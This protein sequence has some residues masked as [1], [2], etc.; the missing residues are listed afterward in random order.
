MSQVQLSLGYDHERPYG[1]LANTAEG[2][3][4]RLRQHDFIVRLCDL[5][6]KEQVSRT[7]FILGDFLERC[8]DSFSVETLRAVYPNT[9]L[10]E[11]QQHS[12]SHKVFRQVPK[13]I[14]P[15]ILSVADFANDVL[16]AGRTIERI[17][18]VRPNGLRT[19]VGYSED[20]ASVPELV[21][22]LSQA[23]I[24][25]VSSD[26]K[27][28]D[29]YRAVLTSERQ[30]HT[31]S[32]IGFPN[33]VEI[34]SHGFHDTVF[35]VEKAKLWF[36]SAPMSQDGMLEHYT[37]LLRE[38]ELIAREGKK[39]SVALCLHPWAVMEYDPQ[40]EIHKK[41]VGIAR[42]RGVEIVSYGKV[43]EQCRAGN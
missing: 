30:P 2:R 11:I 34:P 16:R 36:N 5:L 12:Y 9:N 17:L 24:N 31:Y 40:L 19:P 18:G 25:Y 43:A 13:R 4:F 38:A 42:N 7:F 33:V 32:S 23:G 21:S 35:T 29:E 8:L 20:L 27:M 6:D 15:Q 41:I 14:D 3:D 39:V 10:N 1:S 37:S 28:A 26:L 22:L